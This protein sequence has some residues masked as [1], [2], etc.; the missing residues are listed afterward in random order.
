MRHAADWGE[1]GTRGRCRS[2]LTR[3]KA[4]HETDAARVGLYALGCPPL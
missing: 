3:A 2:K 4:A 1:G